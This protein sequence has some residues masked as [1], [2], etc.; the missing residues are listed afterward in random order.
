MQVTFYASS[1]RYWVPAKPCVRQ[2]WVRHTSHP[3]QACKSDERK[4]DQWIVLILCRR[5]KG[6][7]GNRVLYKLGGLCGQI[8]LPLVISGRVGPFIKFTST[9]PR[10]T[11][12]LSVKLWAN[13][14]FLVGWCFPK[15]SPQGLFSESSAVYFSDCFTGLSHSSTRACLSRLYFQSPE[16]VGGISS[17]STT[18]GC[19]A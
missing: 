8:L 15:C 4:T 10:V 5:N 12:R 18:R 3:Q 6:R 19:W 17:N 13:L 7:C 9:T 11:Q 16:R 2:W 14:R 1:P